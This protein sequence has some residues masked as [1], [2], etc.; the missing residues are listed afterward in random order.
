MP[1]PSAPP[2][3]SSRRDQ[4]FPKL[5]VTEV[6]RLRRFGEV[7]RF[8]D[9]ELLFESG[10]PSPGMFVL[11]NGGVAL[12]RRD[13][14]GNVSR[15]ADHGSGEFVGEIA[16]LSGHPALVDARAVGEVESLLVPPDKLRAVMVADAALGEKIMRALILRRTYLI[17]TGGSGL[18]LVGSTLQPDMIRLQGFLTRNA[19]PH[20]VLDP[21]TSEDAASL[22]E[23]LSPDKEEFP[24]VVCPDGTVL[25]NPSE[26]TLARSIG[27]LSVKAEAPVYDVAI[28]GAGPAGLA[29]AV[30]AASEGLSVLV[31][32]SN[33]FGGQAGASARIENYLGF[34]TGISGLALAARAFTQA[35]KF[36]AEFVIPLK[37]AR[38]DHTMDSD[39]LTLEMSDGWRVDARTV[40]IASGARY[41]RPAIPNLDLYEGRGVW[42]W[43]SSIEARLCANAEVVL[44]GGGN[45]AGQ[46][47]IFLS[48]YAV[49][50]WMLVRG[51]GLASSMSHYLIERIE[52]TSNV[53]LL[54][55][56]EI[57]GLSG[58][59][60][61][62]LESVRW[63]HR[64]TSE[65]SLH[66]IRHVFLFIGAD[67][68]TRWLEDC[69]VVLDDC[70]FVKTG[71]VAAAGGD[72][73]IPAS[74]TLQTNLPGVFAVGDVRF[75]SVKRVG[76]AIGEGT[77]VV[78]QL[79]TS[80]AS[81]HG[82]SDRDQSVANQ[83]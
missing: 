25:R 67:P 9:G 50:V 37:V 77:T 73:A 59:P 10:R 53:E 71:T 56:T 64:R 65:E 79:H 51:E 23:R 29:T 75:G 54:T 44:V 35:Q 7:R 22:I 74:Q 38:L 46:A 42:Y 52:A 81:R 66:P 24:L 12:T 5:S 18:V 62:G 28:V 19:Q 4:V 63:R 58:S 16:H 40:V 48:D 1:K 27:L 15:I 32:D 57:V 45:S 83:A 78:A 60:Q 39:L 34:P 33:A 41:R 43:A 14:L 17:E 2:F 21:E 13:G 76:A 26:E 61:L 82:E 70:G 69:G 47:A 11:I 68:E 55:E 80:L 6:E 36:G 31:V 49:K 72:C 8:Y 20:T 30:Y 3:L